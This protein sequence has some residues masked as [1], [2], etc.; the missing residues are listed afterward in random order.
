[1]KKTAFI[2]DDIYLTHLMPEFHPESRERLVAIMSKLRGS[3]VWSQLIAMSP[4]KASFEDIEAIHDK[5][6]IEKVKNIGH[7]YLD[8]DTYMSE[9]THEAALYAAGAII[10]AIRACKSGEIERAF[11]AVRPPGHHAEADR[12]MGF[13]VYNNVAIGARF[14]QKLGYAKVFVIDFDVH[15]GNG[16]QHSFYGD[17]SVFY[18][19]THQYPHYPG[20]GS[21][22][23][24]GSGKGKGYT[25]NIPMN[26][27][28]GD[29]QMHEAYHDKLYKQVSAFSPD[30]ILVSAG[31]DIH[32]DD[33]LAGF[34]VTDD[35]IRDIVR[36]ILTAKADIPVVFT[37]EGGYDLDAISDGVLISVRELLNYP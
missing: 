14:A 13:C 20:T 22:S 29:K 32:K 33:P 9:N 2:Y 21:T 15:H 30:I 1:M 36:G 19:S 34:M 28:A 25:Y 10:T 35:G 6:Y 7:G 24:T 23:E 5:H 3:D 37:M 16:T 11:C 18:F 27:G 17:D 8:A 4:E 26:Y 12:G 31:Y